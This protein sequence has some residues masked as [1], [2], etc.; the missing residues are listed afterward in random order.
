[1]RWSL[2]FAVAGLL[3]AQAL[4][5]PCLAQENKPENKETRDYYYRHVADSSNFKD[6]RWPVF[7]A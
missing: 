3:T 4:F 2:V 7:G 5:T 1:M 6:G